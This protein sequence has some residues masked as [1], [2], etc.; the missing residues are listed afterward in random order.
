LDRFYS[1]AYLPLGHWAYPLIDNWVASGRATELDPLIQPY[2]R[3]EVARAILQVQEDSPTRTDAAW[4]PALEKEFASELRALRGEKKNN[5]T[6][7]LFLGAGLGFYSQEFRD[8]TRAVLTGENSTDRVLG[9]I[10]F[11][12]SGQAGPVAGA[13]RARYNE[14][15]KY[16]AQFPNGV[17]PAKS[18]PLLDSAYMRIEEGYVELQSRFARVS[19]GRMYQNWG[20]PGV[21]GLLRSNYAYSEEGLNY[22]FGTRTIFLIGSIASYSDF[23]RDTTHYFSIHRLEIRPIDRLVIS[24]SEAVVHGGP[25]QPLVWQFVNP[26]SVW[27]IA[28]NDNDPPHN[29]LGEVSV[30]AKPSR[31]LVLYGSF[32]ADATNLAGSCC[33]AGGTFAVELPTLIRGWGLRGQLTA[34]QSLAYRT[35]LPWEEYTVEGIGLGWDKI[36][37]YMATIEADWLGA[38]RKLRPGSTLTLMPR[39][40]LQW[41]GEQRITELRPPPDQLPDFPRILSGITETTVRPAVA[42]RWRQGI[43]PWWLDAEFDLGVNFVKNYQNQS[44]DD[45]TAFVGNVIVR[46]ETPHWSFGLD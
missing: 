42:G 45:R 44:G 31:G 36:D 23:R 16:D 4:M 43:G 28:A 25:A 2:R 38:T 29:K 41:R 21:H 11:D 6:G 15:Y 37:L 22:R 46:I 9:Q 13:F 12:L 30:W 17:V 26:V 39:L 14:F 10:R 18:M 32:L 33:Q 8:L 7:F 20:L 35:G 24:V 27:H 1:S 5:N 3:I 19:F 34:I 40:D